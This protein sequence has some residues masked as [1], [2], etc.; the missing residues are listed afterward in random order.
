MLLKRQPGSIIAAI[1]VRVAIDDTHATS[2]TGA[3]AL[4]PRLGG[5]LCAN[6]RSQ[7]EGARIVDGSH[8]FRQPFICVRTNVAI[9]P[10]ER[11][12]DVQPIGM[13]S[14][15][16]DAAP[17][18][19]RISRNAVPH[20]ATCGRNQADS[21]ALQC[22]S[23][24]ADNADVGTPNRRA[25]RPGRGRAHRAGAACAG[26]NGFDRDG[27]RVAQRSKRADG[28]LSLVACPIAL[29]PASSTAEKKHFHQINSKTG[30]I[31]LTNRG[32]VMAIEPF[33]KSCSGPSCATTMKCV[34]SA[35]SPGPCQIPK[36]ML[37][38]ASHIL[39]TKSGHFDPSEFKDRYE[40]ELRK[41]VKR[42]AA[43]KPIEVPERA[44]PPTNVVD[45]MEALRKSVW[46]Q[47]GRC[48]RR[49]NLEEEDNESQ[50]TRGIRR[51]TQ[52]KAAG[53]VSTPVLPQTQP[54]R[55][56]LIERAR[57]PAVFALPFS[58][59]WGQ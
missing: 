15:S 27:T 46:R 16:D 38:L 59:P 36:E 21:D 24:L 41:L 50:G 33:A 44:E 31:V 3:S 26:S 29:F 40:T 48:T 23:G 30:N 14:S 42:K 35:N 51:Q 54:R 11:A 32:H 6:A 58:P 18:Y 49:G 9:S 4:P 45:L 2:L 25:R 55:T 12:H 37:S 52:D 53:G 56:G 1:C 17:C 10:T 8:F 43:G 7:S 34:T 57:C 13:P 5:M 28:E 39:H 20:D 22:C 19:C 47:A